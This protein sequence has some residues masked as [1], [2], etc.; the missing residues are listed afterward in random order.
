MLALHP[1]VHI[2]DAPRTFYLDIGGLRVAFAGF[3]Y[4][5][6]NVRSEFPR[7]VEEL[8]PAD[9]PADARLL[10]VHHCFEGAQV[11]V[12][13]YT[14]RTG[15]DVVRANDV[16]GRFDVV[17]TGHVHRYQVLSHDLT[18]RVLDSPIIYSGSIERTAFAEREET[19]GFVIV[20]LYCDRAT[21]NVKVSWEFRELPTRT[22]VVRDLDLSGVG[23][24]VLE[25]RV[26]EL[27]SRLPRDAVVQLRVRGK[28]RNE[29]RVVMGAENMR[30]LAPPTMN[31]DLVFVDGERPTRRGRG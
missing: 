26:R 23:P 1:G 29:T 16:P 10:C 30:K 8:A 4:S 11:G 13:N 20:N 28:P 22:M 14:F 7:L 12:H 18:G 31:L 17:L 9:S 21:E 3:P 15:S 27:L 19:K 25:R 5:R 24:S 6:K 2:F